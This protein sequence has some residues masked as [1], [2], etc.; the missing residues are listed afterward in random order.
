LAKR[1]RG[2]GAQASVVTRALSQAVRATSASAAAFAEADMLEA[3]YGPAPAPWCYLV[4]GAAGRG[5]SLLALK[6]ETALVHSGSDDDD[7]WFRALTERA[8]RIATHAG[9]PIH[10]GETA[11]RDPA[12]CHSLGGVRDEINQWAARSPG[13]SPVDPA[14]FFD[15]EVVHGDEDLAW[16]LREATSAMGRDPRIATRLAHDLGNWIS[17][18]NAFGGLRARDGW[19]DLEADGL[20]HLVGG[21]RALSLKWGIVATATRARLD[22]LAQLAAISKSDADELAGAHEL[23]LDLVLDQELRDIADGIRPSARVAP[24]R[25]SPEQRERLRDALHVIGAIEIVARG[26]FYRAVA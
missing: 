5:E 19:L 13:L 21:I 15:F 18:L 26:Y 17:P 8:T 2:E 6:Q 10:R 12:R 16:D 9:I 7:P 3:G 22:A 20:N 4:L 11:A 24:D 23:C 14:A 25:I 1:L